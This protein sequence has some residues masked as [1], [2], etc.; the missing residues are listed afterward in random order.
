MKRIWNQLY[1]KGLRKPIVSK[2]AVCKDN[3]IIFSVE[4]GGNQSKTD[5]VRMD[6]MT[7]ELTT[8][9]TESNSVRTVGVLEENKIY[10]SSFNGLAYCIDLRGDVVWSTNIGGG[11]A[12]FEV[13]IDEDRIYFFDNTLYCL[14]KKSGDIIW[15]NECES[16]D[17]N[18]TG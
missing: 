5:V 1:R 14:D 15:I 2:N 16:N 6:L 11:N 13:L 17:A 3:Q 10:F 9:L 12:S 18:C 7:K 8:F 4:Y